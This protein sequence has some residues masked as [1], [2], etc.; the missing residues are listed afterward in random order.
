M[1]KDVLREQFFSS[2]NKLSTIEQMV[3][4]QQRE[5]QEFGIKIFSQLIHMS[6]FINEELKE[7]QRPELIVK[8]FL[9]DNLANG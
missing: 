1:Q 4:S 5:V 8:I 3:G 9:Q 6:A 7:F 2:L